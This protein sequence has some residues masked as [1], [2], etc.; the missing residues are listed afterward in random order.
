[1]LTIYRN[2]G[3]IPQNRNGDDIVVFIDLWQKELLREGKSKNSISSYIADI[4][5]FIKWYTETYDEEFQGKLLNMDIKAYESYLLNIR[6]QNINTIL[7]N[8]VALKQFNRFLFNQGIEGASKE[9][10]NTV[11]KNNDNRDR[12]IRVLSNRNLNKLRRSFYS[13]DNFRDI[14][15]FEVLINTGIRVSELIGLELDDIKLTDRNGENNYSYIR[16]RS[17]K[18][19]IYREVP[20]NST[21]RTAIKDY[22]YVRPNCESENIFIGERGALK[23]FAIN[24]LLKKYCTY[25]KID[26]IGPHILRHTFA[27]KLIIDS[28]V[29]LVTISR[30][31]GHSDSKITETF[32]INTS[33]EDKIN[34]VESLDI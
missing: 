7:R 29:D 2:H 31:L 3:T 22:L 9:L 13:V 4:N 25:A 34:A 30:L 12:L 33:I 6:K 21:C 32:Y 1:M 19:N 14:A 28:K 15:I 16:I 8:T 26:S 27:T 20:L 17:G 11:I 18:G 5:K 24:K 10:S 23:R